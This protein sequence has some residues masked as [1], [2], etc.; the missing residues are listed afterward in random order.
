[1]SASLDAIQTPFPICSACV[2]RRHGLISPSVFVSATKKREY[3]LC[4]L[5]SRYRLYEHTKKEC[6]NNN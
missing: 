2:W 3:S 6:Q 1:M 4:N 5:L